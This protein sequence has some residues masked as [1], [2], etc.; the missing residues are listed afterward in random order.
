MT[1]KEIFETVM[2]YEDLYAVCVEAVFKYPNPKKAIYDFVVEN[3]GKYGAKKATNEI[4]E[5]VK[6]V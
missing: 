5:M 2:N 3:F 6:D 4:Y 1:S